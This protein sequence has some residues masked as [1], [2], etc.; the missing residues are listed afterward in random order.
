MNE[1][2][3]ISLNIISNTHLTDRAPTLKPLLVRWRFAACGSCLGHRNS[4][5]YREKERD[6]G[7]AR[8]QCEDYAVVQQT[9]SKRQGMAVE[10]NTVQKGD[11]VMENA[12]PSSH[13]TQ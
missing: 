12:D 6:D 10:V 1:C 11:K 9:G 4:N 3:M 8:C 2:M 5:G 7:E 13:C